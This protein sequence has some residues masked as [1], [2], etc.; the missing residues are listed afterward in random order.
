MSAWQ[1]WCVLVE[2]S[3]FCDVQKPG[4]QAVTHILM[5]KRMRHIIEKGGGLGDQEQSVILTTLWHTE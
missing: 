2:S 1:L 3:S 5:R 4:G